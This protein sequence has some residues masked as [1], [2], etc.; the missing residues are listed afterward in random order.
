V[1]RYTRQT[2]F[3]AVLTLSAA[4]RAQTAP[5]AEPAPGGVP[6][7]AAPA[8]TPGDATGSA[9]VPDAPVPTPAPAPTAADAAR[10]DEIE[11]T[12][13]I[14]LRKNELLEEEAAKRAKEA[15][16]VTIDDKGFS[17]GLPDKSYVLKVRALV[18]TDARFFFKD[19]NLQANDTFARR[20]TARCSRSSTS[21]WFPSSP[22]R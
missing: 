1:I 4:A 10:L 11:Q 17:L 15:P 6:A 12:A 18:Q 16:R 2:V 20:W 22:E 21:G 3:V 9:A 8:P 5:A 14:A 7:D 19:Q 13:R